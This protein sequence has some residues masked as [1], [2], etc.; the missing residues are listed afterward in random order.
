MV[1]NDDI[2]LESSVR[3]T[4]SRRQSR[5]ES[6]TAYV[7]DVPPN[8]G[9]G[10][11][12]TFCV[13]L[14]N[15]HTWGVNSAWGVILAHL[16]SHSTFPGASRIEYS[17]IGGLSISCAMLIGP[18]ASK[19]QKLVGTNI[20]LFL[21]NILLFV[22]LLGASYAYQIW[23]LF[24]TQG[25]CFG[26]GMG[27]LYL[28]AMAVLPHWFSTRRSLSM[29]IAG[30]GAG[31]GGL[32]YNLA[33]GAAVKNLGISMTY[34]IL[35]FCS[36]GANSVSSILLRSRGS[37]HVDTRKK[38][39]KLSDFGRMEILL[40]ML[41]GTVTEFGYIALF[42]SLP[43]Y[44]ASIGL[45]TGQGSI[46]GA[47]LNLGLTVGR[48]IVGYCSDHFGRIT[49][50]T[51]VTAFCGLYCLAIWIP[52]HS[53]GVL[54]LF[55]LLAGTVCGTFWGTV[56][57]VMVEVVGLGRLPST[58]TLICFILAAPTAVAEPIALSLVNGSGY[59][60]TKIFVGCMFFLGALTLWILR[61]WKCYE[62][63]VKSNQG[64]GFAM[65]KRSSI[66]GFVKWVRPRK[67]LMQGPI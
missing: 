29:G 67:L 41:W 4:E 23:H 58:W 20:T 51:I 48:P 15:I 45:S 34:K 32:I 44:A 60:P 35:A 31:I 62:V 16:L 27:L 33:A 54:I 56:T 7:H 3:E 30:A 18:L 55:S 25:V 26:V 10:W 21:G 28:P 61:L 37:P 9:Y 52:A 2:Q 42:Y 53:F 36:L 8:G 46:I 14:I 5:R 1:N 65:D 59:L 40:L 43:D 12:C 49:V 13:F 11:V 24:L 38:T 17:F 47:M 64:E 39:I 6:S 63:E 19:M 57:P 22:A 50:P 66:T